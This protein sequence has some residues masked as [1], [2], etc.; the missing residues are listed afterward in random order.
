MEIVTVSPRKKLVRAELCALTESPGAFQ[1]LLQDTV[2][3]GQQIQLKTSL[4]L[5]GQQF[6]HVV[7]DKSHLRNCRNCQKIIVSF[8][9][10]WVHKI[11][12]ITWVCLCKSSTAAKHYFKILK[13]GNLTLLM[14]GCGIFLFTI[15]RCFPGRG[16]YPSFSLLFPAPCSALL[17]HSKHLLKENL[18]PP[19]YCFPFISP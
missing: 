16:K 6:R 9:L 18:F 19:L 15:P 12:R 17:C 1:G 11:N 14:L 10:L 2:T 13:W 8:R 3:E 4:A 5:E 7:G